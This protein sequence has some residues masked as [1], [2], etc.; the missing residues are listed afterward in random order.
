VH[1][2]EDEHRQPSIGPAGGPFSGVDPS[3]AAVRREV[4]E[5]SGAAMS[6]DERDIGSR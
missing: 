3:A 4:V 1:E 6:S 2:A 5:P